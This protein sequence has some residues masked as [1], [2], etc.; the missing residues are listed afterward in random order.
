MYV[1][2]RPCPNN[3]LSLSSENDSVTLQVRM[4]DEASG[5]GGSNRALTGHADP[6]RRS[7]TRRRRRG[8]CYSATESCTKPASQAFDYD[9]C[10]CD[11]R[12]Q[13]SRVGFL[14]RESEWSVTLNSLNLSP[15]DHWDVLPQARS[16]KNWGPMEKQVS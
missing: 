10:G 6:C 9:G 16:L 13:G 4:G 15:R 11:S 12:M 5:G 7:I 8:A 14:S 1:Q 3:L 2:F